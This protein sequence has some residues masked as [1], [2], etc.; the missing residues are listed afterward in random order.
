MLGYLEQQGRT[1][2]LKGI[3]PVAHINLK[4]AWQP[5]L[6]SGYPLIA[7]V[8]ARRHAPP[9]THLAT[10]HRLDPVLQKGGGGREGNLPS[11]KEKGELD[12]VSQ[13]SEMWVRAKRGKG[14]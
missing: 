12:R 10:L 1:F 13:L 5:K 8:E 9:P 3:F 14:F 2:L 7:C 11:C 6:I 4:I